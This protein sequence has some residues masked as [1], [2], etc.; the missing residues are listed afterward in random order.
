MK[1]GPQKPQIDSLT[2][3]CNLSLTIATFRFL[4]DELYDIFEISNKEVLVCLILSLYVCD[5]TLREHHPLATTWH[6]PEKKQMTVDPAHLRYLM[7]PS[8]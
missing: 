8:Q 7:I 1:V 5:V 4:Y 3:I 6:V 2:G